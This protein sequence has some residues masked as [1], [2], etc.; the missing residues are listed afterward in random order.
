MSIKSVKV[1]S[2]SYLIKKT[3]LDLLDLGEEKHEI[4]LGAESES[5]SLEITYFWLL[6]LFLLT[7]DGTDLEC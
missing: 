1:K 3:Y 5:L 7:R 6:S 2:L 4:Q